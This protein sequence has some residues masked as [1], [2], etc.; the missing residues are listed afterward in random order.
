MASVCARTAARYGA[1]DWW[2]S[3]TIWWRISRGRV[4]GWAELGDRPGAGAQ[5]QPEG[6][7]PLRIIPQILIS[8]NLAEDMA[9]DGRVVVATAQNGWVEVS[10]VEVG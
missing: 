1:R 9:R 10:S 4:G 7:Q 2:G 8:P 3:E 6:P 5:W